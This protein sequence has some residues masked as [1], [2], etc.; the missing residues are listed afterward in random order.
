MMHDNNGIIVTSIAAACAEPTSALDASADSSCTHD[1]RAMHCILRW[2]L[3]MNDTD[4]IIFTIMG[5]NLSEA[6]HC[7]ILLLSEEDLV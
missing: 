6:A 7:D 1:A 4:D 5:R 2:E 3:R